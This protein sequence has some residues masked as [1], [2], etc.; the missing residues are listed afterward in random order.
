MLLTFSLQWISFS[1]WLYST[2][3]SQNSRTCNNQLPLA[4]KQPH[5]APPL[6]PVAGHTAAAY[7][8][9]HWPGTVF[10]G[11]APHP[12]ILSSPRVWS[13]LGCGAVELQKPS[14]S[15]QLRASLK[16]HPALELSRR[17]APICLALRP[18]LQ[19]GNCLGHLTPGTPDLESVSLRAFTLDHAVCSISIG[20]QR[21]KRE[22]SERS[23]FCSQLIGQTELHDP[24]YFPKA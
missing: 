18:L 8:C 23:H 4:G 2:P 22:I 6:S 13:Q 7:S 20:P 24:T 21:R 12:N 16:D 10:S 17:P 9:H 15:G 14:L 19:L 3:G 1:R 5:Q 11:T